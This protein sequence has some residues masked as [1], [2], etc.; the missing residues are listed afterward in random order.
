[1][2]SW[3]IA[4]GAKAEWEARTRDSKVLIDG[5]RRQWPRLAN[6]DFVRTKLQLRV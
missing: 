6:V 3:G 2:A 4:S 5:L 1:M